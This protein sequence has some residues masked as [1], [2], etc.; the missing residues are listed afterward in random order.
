MFLD[1]GDAPPAETVPELEAKRAGASYQDVID[2]KLT[3]SVNTTSHSRSKVEPRGRVHSGFASAQP[4]APQSTFSLRPAPTPA[5][6]AL[7]D[8][9][10]LNAAASPFVPSITTP[11][12]STFAPA[13]V[14]QPLRQAPYPQQSASSKPAGVPSDDKTQPPKLS[15]SNGPTA[16]F[17]FSSQKTPSA[18]SSAQ[19]PASV[20]STATAPPVLAPALTTKPAH[21]KPAPLSIIP[22]QSLGRVPQISSSRP[23]KS[24]STR[25]IDSFAKH[26]ANKALVMLTEGYVRKVTQHAVDSEYKRRNDLES[27]LALARRTQMETQLVKGLLNQMV[28]SAIRDEVADAYGEEIWESPLRRKVFSWWRRCAQEKRDRRVRRLQR[29]VTRD[30]FSKRVKALTISTL[31]SANADTSALKTG[32]SGAW[33]VDDMDQDTNTH[34]RKVSKHPAFWITPPNVP[35]SWRNERR[36]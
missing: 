32:P 6:K 27:R 16:S 31:E 5:P 29:S 33:T 24:L 34:L 21:S 35:S 20:V 13:P 30:D 23:T 1:N 22:A 3:N 10:S 14:P 7:P 26:L 17:S 8:L 11:G 28:E 18:A 25:Q 19:F 4:T 15:S 2:G 12:P 9:P 36:S